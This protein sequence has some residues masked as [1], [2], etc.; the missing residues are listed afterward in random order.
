MSNHSSR[1]IPDGNVFLQVQ[2][3]FAIA[4]GWKHPKHQQQSNKHGSYL[5]N[6]TQNNKQ[7]KGYREIGTFVH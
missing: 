2:A 1:Y 5:K 7:R 4:P 6:K 3:L